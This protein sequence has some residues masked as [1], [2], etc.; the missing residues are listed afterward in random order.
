MI[1]IFL[2]TFFCINLFANQLD[3]SGT[4][5]RGERVSKGEDDQITIKKVMKWGSSAKVRG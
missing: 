4:G 2:T 5:Q 3:L 1:K